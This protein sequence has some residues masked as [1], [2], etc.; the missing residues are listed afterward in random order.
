M[1][2][3]H[4]GFSERV[5]EFGFN[6]EYAQ[7]N[8]ALLATAPHIPTQNEEQWLGYD[9]RFEI[10]KHGG[11]IHSVALQHKVARYVD[12]S[13]GTNKKFRDAVGGPYL[14]FRINVDQF[15]L[16][17]SF[18]SSGLSGVEFV[19]CAPRFSQRKNMDK[20]YL[21]R[22]VMKESIWIDPKGVGSVTS[23]EAHSIVYNASGSKAFV[24]SGEPR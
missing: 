7:K 13:C 19:Y 14:A 17:E 18:A 8:R 22:R 5:F 24:F 21:K 1:A 11:A 15:N 2:V 6:A 4:A 20:H 10:K 9:V 3:N 12:G 23:S 16:I